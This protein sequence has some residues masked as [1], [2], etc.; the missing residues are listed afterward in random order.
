MSNIINAYKDIYTQ[1]ANAF[2]K[3]AYIPLASNVYGITLIALT[4]FFGLSGV[5]SAISGKKVFCVD[6][7]SSHYNGLMVLKKSI[8]LIVRGCVAQVP[9]IGNFAI[10]T[11]DILRNQYRV[12]E[13]QKRLKSLTLLT[14]A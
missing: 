4:V 6:A 9:V 11:F 8:V 12:C 3:L 7:T 13:D 5:C 14:S 2:D 1:E 10:A